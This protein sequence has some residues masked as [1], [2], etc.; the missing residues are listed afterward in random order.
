M[1]YYLRPV[2]IKSAYLCFLGQSS[3]LGLLNE[4]LWG[5]LIPH[6]YA[7][8]LSHL[9]SLDV[10]N[11]IFD[12]ENTARNFSLY[13]YC[14]FCY[15]NILIKFKNYFANFFSDTLFFLDFKSRSQSDIHKNYDFMKK[16]I[17]V[18][19]FVT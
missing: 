4:I 7:T 16:F 9:M 18:S 2:L 13:K 6:V 5:I 11:L 3:F 14:F 1:K 17:E 8:C 10:I 15:Y 19:I 12:S